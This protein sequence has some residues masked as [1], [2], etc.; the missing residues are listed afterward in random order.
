SSVLHEPVVAAMVS[1][2]IAVVLGVVVDRVI[3][4]IGRRLEAAAAGRAAD[5]GGP[6]S[7]ATTAG[8][9]TRTPAPT[10]ETARP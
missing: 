3:G 5:D 10:G 9:T 8:R 4:T 6:R 2:V 1:M 7:P